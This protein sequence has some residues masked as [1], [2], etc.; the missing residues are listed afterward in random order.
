MTTCETMIR[1]P[2]TERTVDRPV[3]RPRV[4]IVEES[5]TLVLLADVPGASESDTDV[6]L[7]KNVLTIRGTISPREFEGHTLAWSEYRVADFERAFTISKDIDRDAI[8][9]TVKDGVLRV[10]LPKRPEAGPKRITVT[11]A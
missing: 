8:E 4:D 10:T 2:E 9:A 3:F 11:S 7:E 1:K 5:G 6:S